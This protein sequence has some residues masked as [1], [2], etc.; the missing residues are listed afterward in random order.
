MDRNL[1]RLERRAAAEY[2]DPAEQAHLV[3]LQCMA[4]GHDWVE[5]WDD[6][7]KNINSRVEY[8]GFYFHCG[9]CD[10]KAERRITDMDDLGEIDISKGHEEAA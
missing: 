1:R 6:R 7:Q 8:K 5:G 10:P 2:L 4:Y 3:R 9:R